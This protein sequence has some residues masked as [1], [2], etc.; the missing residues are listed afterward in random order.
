M[1]ASVILSTYNRSKLLRRVLLSLASVETS[2]VGEWEL[3]VVDNNSSDD[4]RLVVEAEIQAGRLPIRYLFEKQQGKSFALN[5]AV[6]A[7]SGELTAFVDDDVIVTTKWLRY[8]LQPFDDVAVMGVGG[9]V[10]PRW[11]CVPPKW[12]PKSAQLTSG[13][14]VMFDLGPEPGR[15][16]EAPFG[17]NMAFRR[18]MFQRYGLFRVDLG[19]KPGSEIR[20][21]DSEFSSRLLASGEQLVYEP[22]ALVLHDVPANRA[23]KRF[24]VAWWLDKGRATIRAGSRE[25]HG[26]AS[27]FGIPIVLYR[28]LIRHALSGI[29]CCDTNTRFSSALRTCYVFGQIVEYYQ[30]F[31]NSVVPRLQ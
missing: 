16:R 20:G 9:K 12:L 17:T 10:L 5:A 29:L 6:Q 3:I 25:F 13:P 30:I 28:R 8:L 31:R 23:K 15:L 18:I 4:T 1:R 24:F 19:P 7:S 21:E 2:T 11:D 27:F 22:A 26:R 14:L